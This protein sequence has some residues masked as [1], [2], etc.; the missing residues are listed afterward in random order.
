MCLLIA[1]LAGEPLDLE[2]CENATVQNDDGFGVAYLSADRKSV[3]IMKFRSLDPESQHIVIKRIA[4]RGPYLAHWRYGTSGGNVRRLAHP[5]RISRRCAL[6][7][8]GVMQIE[9]QPADESD[10]SWLS[11]CLR[12]IGIRSARDVI[13]TIS[14]M[15]M[16]VLGGSKFATLSANGDIYLHNEKAGIRKGSIWHSN[17]CGIN[18]TKYAGG[19]AVRRGNTVVTTYGGGSSTSSALSRTASSSGSAGGYPNYN[20]DN[21]MSEYYARK[22]AEGNKTSTTPTESGVVDTTPE[23]VIEPSNTGVSEESLAQDIFFDGVND[24]T[25]LEDVATFQNDDST[26][27]TVVI[28]K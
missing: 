7:H 16:S 15:P 25:V 20:Y 5:F 12:D 17:Y 28:L 4:R 21:S 6:A 27:D 24:D 9:G 13:T 26:G 3:K 18:G 1:S 22:E 11:K 8:N 10:T 23:T 14:N 19:R 2:T